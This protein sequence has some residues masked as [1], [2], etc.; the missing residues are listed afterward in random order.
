MQQS[1][2]QAVLYQSCTL[3]SKCLEPST[4]A[5]SSSSDRDGMDAPG[6]SV[7]ATATLSA[8]YPES[9]QGDHLMWLYEVSC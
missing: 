7:S 6:W 4:L 9:L 1:T 3:S 5:I 2:S 8:T